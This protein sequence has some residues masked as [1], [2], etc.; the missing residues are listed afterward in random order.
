MAL[1]AV[2]LINV[3]AAITPAFAGLIGLR[4][5]A[6]FAATF[7]VP[8]ASATAISLT[9]PEVRG[10]ALA[11]VAGGTTVAFMLG[12][13]AGSVIGGAFGWRAT[14]V[15]AATLSALAAIIVR[16]AIPAVPPQPRP[17][18]TV[19]QLLRRDDVA[20]ALM[21]IFLGF[22][23]TFT[24]V[25]YVGP[26]VST[27]TGATG[28]HVG[29]YQLCVGVGSLIGV[30]LGGW[31]VDRGHGRTIPV[32]VFAVMMVTLSS[33]TILLSGGLAEFAPALLAAIILAGAAALF[34]LIPAMQARLVATAPEAAPLLLG[35]SGSVMFLGQ[36]AGAMFGG[37]I[38]DH[39][40]FPA[41][42]VAG[43]SLALGALLFSAASA[44][45]RPAISIAPAE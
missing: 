22:A 2:A 10:R 40:G 35:A 8:I 3:L 20:P 13:P 18:G 7:I 23:A 6:G 19:V 1:V 21:S 27:I 34:T 36:G 28:G 24:V 11:F 43:A 5:A 12:I 33:Y 31:L 14:F 39:L 41:I 45:R 44:L 29:L 32:G 9:T 17:A 25:A 16:I 4:I 30:P 26:V 37:V 42:G 15:F 38:T